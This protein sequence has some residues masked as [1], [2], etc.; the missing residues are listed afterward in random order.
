MKEHDFKATLENMPNK[1][2]SQKDMI[3]WLSCCGE[4]TIRKAL[5]IADTVKSLQKITRQDVYAY[6]V[7][8]FALGEYEEIKKEFENVPNP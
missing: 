5:M 8:S 1:F 3:D 6:S 7:I 4:K 2:D